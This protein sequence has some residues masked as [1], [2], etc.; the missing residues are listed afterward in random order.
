MLS[1]AECLTPSYPLLVS[2]AYFILFEY[3]ILWWLI[4]L[5][6]TGDFYP[7]LGREISFD[8]LNY[9]FNLG[10]NG[11]SSNFVYK[12]QETQEFFVEVIMFELFLLF[13]INFRFIELIIP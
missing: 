8:C 11:L 9:K 4:M 13:A 6:L 12:I 10:K 1:I 7:Y 2:P 3:L 5:L